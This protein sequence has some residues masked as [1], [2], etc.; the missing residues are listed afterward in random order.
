[1]LYFY[2]YFLALFLVNV[3]PELMHHLPFYEMPRQQQCKIYFKLNDLG[4]VYV[5][6]DI[7]CFRNVKLLREG[8]SKV[9]SK[10]RNNG[11]QLNL[12]F[13]HPW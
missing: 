4:N 11:V 7:F 2:L 3:M 9:N 5:I 6:V 10:F 8:Y 1:M 12:L 13:P